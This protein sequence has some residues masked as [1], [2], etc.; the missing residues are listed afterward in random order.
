MTKSSALR[1]RKTIISIVIAVSMFVA[2]IPF[3]VFGLI[4][5]ADIT[6]DS[7]R[8]DIASTTFSYAQ[9][10]FATGL[11]YNQH[12][13]SVNVNGSTETAYFSTI[14][15]AIDPRITGSFTVYWMYHY[16][17]DFT[18]HEVSVDTNSTCTYT[19]S[20]RNDY[21]DLMCKLVYTPSAT[22]IANG[23][24]I[25][26]TSRQTYGR[27]VFWTGDLA[28]SDNGFGETPVAG[29]EY[30]FSEYCAFGIAL[31][32]MYDYLTTGTFVSDPVSSFASASVKKTYFDSA[33]SAGFTTDSN[34]DI[35]YSSSNT[36]VATVA[37][38]GTI[39]IKA[40]GTTTITAKTAATSTFNES[41]TTMTLTVDK[42]TP[43]LSNIS[44]TGITYGQSLASSTISG[45]A[46]VGSKIVSGSWSWVN[47]SITPSAGSSSY[48][49]RFTPSDAS[50]NSVTAKYTITVDTSSGYDLTVGA[51]PITYGDKLSMSVL[52]KTSSIEGSIV[53]NNPNAAPNAGN[54]SAAW[55]FT[56]N[57]SNYAVKTGTTTVVVNKAPL[58]VNITNIAA[59]TYGQ[60]LS[61][62]TVTGTV[63]FG[64][65]DVTG[66]FVWQNGSTTKPSVADSGITMYTLQ[67]VPTSTNYEI[68]TTSRTI[69]VDRATAITDP[70][71]VSLSA[72]PISYEQTLN[73]SII[74]SNTTISVPGTFEWVDRYI[75][76]TVA[77]SGSSYAVRFI[78]TDTVNYNTIEGLSCTVT[79]NKADPDMS[80]VSVSATGIT[81][82]EKLSD[83]I[84]SGNT[85]VAG[86][87]EWANGNIQPS[88]ADSDTTEYDIVFIPN[89]E[90]NYNRATVKVKLSVSKA[91]PIITSE[92]RASIS[93]SGITY[94]NSLA[95]STLSGT[96]PVAGNYY[97]DDDNIYPDVADSNRTAYAVTFVP[98]D[99]DNYNSVSGLSCTV[100]VA[101][102]T[103][104]ITDDMETSISATAITYGQSLADAVLT[105][106][107]P[108][109][110]HY[111]WDDDSIC[112]SVADSNVTEYGVTFVPDDL[113]NYNVATGLKCKLT[114]N[115]ATPV[116]PDNIKA[117]VSG[118]EIT[119]GQ[120][121]NDSIL[122]GDT[123]I[124]GHYEWAD[125]SIA[126]SVSDSLS[127]CYSIIFVPDDTVNYTTASFTITVKVNPLV[128]VVTDAMKRSITST[129]IVY[130]QSLGDSTLS[131]TTPVPGTY[132]WVSTGIQPSVSDS[133]I[134]EYEVMFVPDD[135]INYASVTGITAKL[136]VSKATPVISSSIKATLSAS[137]ISYGQKL[138]DSIVSGDVPL[139]GHWEW[140]D[141]NLTPAVSDSNSTEYV[142]IF[143]PHDSVNYNTASTTLTLSVDRAAPRFDEDMISASDISYGQKL[144]E[145]VL[146]YHLP[147]LNGSEI[148]GSL[149]WTD[150]DIEPNAG[151]REYD[152]IFTPDDRVNFTT[153]TISVPVTIK[154]LVPSISN[155]TIASVSASPITYGQSLADS[156]ITGDVVMSGHYEWED[157]TIKPAVSDSE[158]TSYNVVFKPDD[159]NYADVVI[160]VT[161]KVNKAVLAIPS[162]V[163]DSISAS[164][165]EYGQRLSES[166]LTGITPA[167]GN[168][169]W[170]EAD[171]I[172]TVNGE[173]KF[174]VVFMPLD[175][176]NY[177]SIEVGKVHVNVNK[178][179]PNLTEQDWLSINPSWIIYGQTLADSVIYNSSSVPGRINWVDTNIK[180]TVADSQRT[181]YIALFTPNDSEN[182][183]KVQLK[184]KVTVHKAVPELPEDIADQLIVTPIRFGSSL[185]S[186][187]ITC[188]NTDIIPGK[189]E[190]AD[191]TIKPAI[192]DSD[193]TAYDVIFVPSDSANYQTVSLSSTVHVDKIEYDSGVYGNVSD[194]I[195]VDSG[196]SVIYDFS[197][198]IRVPDW[199]VVGK[200]IVD[201][202]GIIDGYIVVRDGKASF[203]IKSGVFRGSADLVFTVSSS[204]YEDF[205]FTLTVMVDE[206]SHNGKTHIRGKVDP[207]WDEAGYT[208]DTI[209][210]ICDATLKYGKIIPALKTECKHVNGTHKE[211]YE[212]AT[213][214]YDG[215]TGDTVCNDCGAVVQYGRIISRKDHSLKTVNAV[216]AT[217]QAE[218]YTGDTI[219][220]QCGKQLSMGVAIPKTN[221]IEGEGV[222]LVQPTVGTAGKMA[223]YCAVC[224][225]LLRTAVI[226][227]L[228]DP[229]DSK[230]DESD[231]ETGESDSKTD[232]SDFETGESINDATL[233]AEFTEEAEGHEHVFG[234]WLHD[235]TSHWRK[236][237]YCGVIGD[238]VEHDWDDGYYLTA[239]CT[240][241]GTVE[242]VCRVCGNI[243]IRNEDGGHRLSDWIFD[244]NAHYRICRICGEHFDEHIHTFGQ[245]VSTEGADE[246]GAGEYEHQ[247]EV[248]GFEVVQT[249]ASNP[250]VGGY[251]NRG[252]T[253]TSDIIS[254]VPSSE[255]ADGDDKHGERGDDDT[256]N[257]NTGVADLPKRVTFSVV[258]SGSLSA[259]IIWRRRKKK[260]THD[261]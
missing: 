259:A 231:F 90:D 148:T 107:G 114:I 198:S 235:D 193:K 36:N 43:T 25:L 217:C 184:L 233:E 42:A 15:C 14:R 118:S 248:C 89:D 213:C 130:G 221:H 157:S 230:T 205:D 195:S 53:W 136:E 57:D 223:Y 239:T 104:N 9:P 58:T 208:G 143:V 133:N 156:A 229:S 18:G 166:L 24:R 215:Y 253:N 224:G 54:Y 87:Y 211:G 52:T 120:T 243:E 85:P 84:I 96:T 71:S 88:V 175:S 161:L 34:G 126:P 171:T 245:W 8:E 64:S 206:C 2:Q 80:T 188:S 117:S 178:S 47:S 173:N 108:I 60:S 160:A 168:Y 92:M 202:N 20:S 240:S 179:D 3:D 27:T 256:N 183:N 146:T 94:G 142:L 35:T 100:S 109:S 159:A 232:E 97:W 167:A 236:C 186:S 180:P 28:D 255:A 127:T 155:E 46:K 41:T 4:A 214:Q 78:P 181:E 17:T 59:I 103:P 99:T 23:V 147:V 123:P 51:S 6:V 165:I 149:E 1:I 29:K 162:D 12:T 137:T 237:K 63:K 112:P 260:K 38:D 26:K 101:K 111:V 31:G 95:D 21:P 191:S 7:S 39:T 250:N 247:C 70:S 91:T 66:A 220:S 138:L 197:K 194:T 203:Q 199:A 201:P 226:P 182:Y 128:P 200:Q 218:G 10:N 164:D 192:S 65:T 246:N 174:M 234:G 212:K 72:T 254:D 187:V 11:Y 62:A 30:K 135:S 177:E 249:F 241:P 110:G 145:S 5:S 172:P 86:R 185:A 19:T 73:D 258:F 98:T 252:D 210:D 251:D 152:A 257:P 44:A 81:Y 141:P 48:D 204:L 116:I 125:S 189:F 106:D 124:S 79:V 77:D 32:D 227:A 170:K 140:D 196:E 69:K 144:S 45:T 83:S 228:D 37:S 176:D 242:Y 169:V 121:L 16:T 76:P 93:A 132:K 244:N 163:F 216:E 238:K 115:K 56:P 207:T 150:G 190:W 33:F 74:T 151:Q 61:D 219:C 40:A 153:A 55:T 13:Q 67:F 119:Y 50:V 75:A 222:V 261:E 113:D 158:S 129:G 22:D 139:A 225:T 131:G 105:G 68:Y 122:T 82:G 49:V 154:Q 134:T 102:A 209:C